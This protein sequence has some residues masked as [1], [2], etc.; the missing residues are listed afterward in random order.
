MA[1]PNDLGQGASGFHGDVAVR[2]RQVLASVET[3][4]ADVAALQTAMGEVVTLVNELKSDYNATLAKLDADAGDTGGD[5]DY[6]ATNAVTSP[7]VTYP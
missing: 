3:A 6:A 4:G 2:V 1:L 5:S 7:S